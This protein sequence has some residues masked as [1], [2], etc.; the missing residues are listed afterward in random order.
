MS[1][2]GSCYRSKLFAK[3]LA[4]AGIRHIRT[5]PYTPRTNGKTERFIQTLLRGWAYAKPYQSSQRRNAALAP[6]INRYNHRRPML[7]SANDR[8]P[9]RSA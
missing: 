8:Q 9:T 7:A 4:D 1:D 6:F 5:R 3:A 2:N